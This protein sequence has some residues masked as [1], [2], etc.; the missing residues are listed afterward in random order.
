M[1]TKSSVYTYKVFFFLFV[2]IAA[3][4]TIN[5]FQPIWFGINFLMIAELLLYLVWITGHTNVGAFIE[6]SQ[7]MHTIVGIS[8]VGMWLAF[9]INTTAY[10]ID[11]FKKYEPRTME[12]VVVI[13]FISLFATLIGVSMY[14]H[15]KARLSVQNEIR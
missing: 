13:F 9:I 1:I 8:H 3:V 2:T 14:Y 15:R 11:D 10:A 5:F 7:L 4:V 6:K 12:Y